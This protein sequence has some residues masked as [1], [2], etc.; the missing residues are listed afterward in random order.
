MSGGGKGAGPT[1]SATLDKDTQ[2]YVQG[3]RNQAQTASQV[4]LGVNPNAPDLFSGPHGA[5]QDAL[6]QLQQLQGT[7]GL[8]DLL[9]GAQQAISNLGFAGQTGAQG[10]G[11]FANPYEQQVLA[12]IQ[13]DIAH[14]MG[15]AGV[16]AN[17][18]STLQGAF[19]GDRSALAQGAAQGEVARGGIN[20]LAQARQSGY[21]QQLNALMQDRNRAAQLGMGGLTAM[22]QGLGIGAGLAGAQF[23]MGETFRGIQNQQNM[24]PLFRQ[25]QA[26]AM[27]NQ[28]VG[29][30]GQNQQTSGGN[31]PIA[32]VAGGAIAGSTFGPAGAIVGGGLGLLGGLF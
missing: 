9:G 22:G 14:Q 29:P 15:L 7:G 21:A 18:Q 5:S 19:S 23:G 25:Q 13:G 28:G 26:L 2:Q 6:S 32:G 11:A 12:G 4:A 10:I 17:Q 1:T 31:N 20:T 27:L 3:L 16:N 30:F 8:Q 24:E